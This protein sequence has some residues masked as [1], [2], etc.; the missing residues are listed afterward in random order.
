MS[1]YL[2]KKVEEHIN[3]ILCNTLQTFRPNKN[4]IY[5]Q[6]RHRVQTSETFLII[7][8]CNTEI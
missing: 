1:N 8:Q 7:D 3:N 6:Y 2:H 5:V 4:L